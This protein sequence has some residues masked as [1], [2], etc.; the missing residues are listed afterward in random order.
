MCTI[1][2]HA[3]KNALDVSLRMHANEREEVKKVFAGEIAAAVGLERYHH[4][5]HDL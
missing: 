3:T 2:A 5:R 4:F 1:L